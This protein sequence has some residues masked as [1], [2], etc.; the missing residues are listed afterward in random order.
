M[1][2]AKSPAAL[3]APAILPDPADLP[4]DDGVLAGVFG[5]DFPGVPAARFAP[6]S[7][8]GARDDPFWFRDPVS[9]PSSGGRF[10]VFGAMGSGS[11]FTGFSQTR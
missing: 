11:A 5:L 9:C 3:A 7:T 6:N 8:A 1:R 2:E 4:G 10:G